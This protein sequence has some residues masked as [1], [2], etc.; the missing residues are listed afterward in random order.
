VNLEAVLRHSQVRD[1]YRWWKRRQPPEQGRVV[2]SQRRVYILPTRHGITF[3]LALLIMLIGSVNYGLSLGYVLTFLLAGMAIVSILH[4]F[5][6]LAHLAV[7][8]GKV[9]P[10]FAGEK[11][12]FE[13]YLENERNE[14]RLAVNAT[15]A[16]DGGAVVCDVPAR[17]TARVAIPVLAQR[18]GWLELPRIT[19]DT[20]YPLGLFRAW[21][22][23]Q[24]AMRTLVY[25]RPD[26]SPLPRPS[27]LEGNG[28][29]VMS[30][31][32][33]EDFSGLRPY[34]P[35]DS[36]R[37]VAWKAA[38][39]NEGM[40]TKLFSGRAAMELIFDWK[41]LPGVL[42]TEARLSRLTRWVLLAHAQG[43]R[44]AVHLPGRGIDLGEGD[45]Q[46]AR[47][48]QELALFNEEGFTEGKSIPPPTKEAQSPFGPPG[49]G[50]PRQAA[51]HRE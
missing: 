11:A 22:Y 39:R 6:N 31:A 50:T 48:L 51:G 3:G 34:Q 30:G 32:G 25:P 5:R 2:L 4:T 47:C 38:A 41:D 19:L 27:P 35:S 43:A 10:V 20:R 29:S 9:E 15:G 18:R 24:P 40:L 12:Q 28:A 8:A 26:A 33:S 42:D 1:F 44:Y 16:G 49:I 17:A 23:V 7:T 37:H 46:L 45:D 13:I 21:S 14:A 36:P